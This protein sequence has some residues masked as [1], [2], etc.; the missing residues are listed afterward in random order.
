MMLLL[1]GSIRG[2]AAA[3]TA[4]TATEMPLQQTKK[5]KQKKKKKKTSS[6]SS[7][8]QQQRHSSS[9][10]SF[11]VQKNHQQQPHFF[12]Q[13]IRH[14]IRMVVLQWIQPNSTIVYNLM[15][16][17]IHGLETMLGISLL[18]HDDDE[19]QRRPSEQ[20]LNTQNKKK[21]KKKTSTTQQDSPKLSSSS[22]SKIQSSAAASK[23]QSK[24]SSSLESTKTT[25][26]KKKKTNPLITQTISTN[27]PNYRIQRELQKFMQDPPEHLRVKIGSK[28]IRI[29]IVEMQGVGIY[30]HET[31]HLRI[32]FPKNYPMRPPSV[33]FVP[34]NIPIHEH[35]YTNGDICLSL[36]GKDWRPTMTAESIA[37]SILSILASATSKSLPMDNARHAGNKPGEYQENWVYHDDSC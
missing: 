17:F 1:V 31:F 26:T 28:N 23:K 12:M 6:S 2:G 36:L 21:K 33:Y 34:P 27:S 15:S 25:T 8:K 24:Q 13:T 30:E 18:E 29:W 16:K 32:Q 19:K 4:S 14:W 11:I 35:V 37:I 22:S 9:S 20:K 3:T 10:S 7:T 5:S